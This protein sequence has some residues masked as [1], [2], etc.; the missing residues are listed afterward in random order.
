MNN[1]TF[2]NVQGDFHTRFSYRQKNRRPVLSTMHRCD[3]VLLMSC[4]PLLHITLINA[5]CRCCGCQ[6]AFMKTQTASH[7]SVVAKTELNFNAHQVEFVPVFLRLAFQLETAGDFG[8]AG[9]QKSGYELF[10][11]I[12]NDLL[13]TI[14]TQHEVPKNQ[15]ETF[16]RAMTTMYDYQRHT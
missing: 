9:S 11:R 5:R 15:F 14:W 12:P 4:Y 10:H 13:T 16:F 1:S 6:V 8:C 7:S 3:C 2:R